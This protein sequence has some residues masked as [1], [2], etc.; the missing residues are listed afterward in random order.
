MADQQRARR[1]P[2]G[3]M[4]IPNTLVE[5]PDLGRAG[6]GNLFRSRGPL[7][8]RSAG[9]ANDARADRAA[10]ARERSGLTKILQRSAPRE[11]VA[12][13]LGLA[14]VRV[15]GDAPWDMRVH[16]QR[17]HA[18][19][20]AHG[21]LGLGEAYMDG[22][23]DAEDLGGLLHRVLDARLDERVGGI[24]DVALYVQSKLMNLQNGLR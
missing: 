17:L 5:A 6:A 14:G 8:I 4:G 7:G 18:R 11:R 12:H 15:D 13:L 1:S 3:D 20:I 16:D 21:S 22:W 23:W 19:V 10:G 24:D 9:G 2:S